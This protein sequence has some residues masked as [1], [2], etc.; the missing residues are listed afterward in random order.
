MR[1]RASVL[2]DRRW[3]DDSMKFVSFGCFGLRGVPEVVRSPRVQRFLRVPY[4]QHKIVTGEV[5]AA[6][7]SRLVRMKSE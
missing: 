7:D 5:T 3:K 2:S 6:H 4:G 1:P